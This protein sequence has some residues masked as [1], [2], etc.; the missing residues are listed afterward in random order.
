MEWDIFLG[1]YDIR[2]EQKISFM[3]ETKWYRIWPRTNG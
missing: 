2:T 3:N 1:Y